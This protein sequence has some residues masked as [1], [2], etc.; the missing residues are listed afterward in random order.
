M[1]RKHSIGGKMSTSLWRICLLAV[2]SIATVVSI[3]SSS[4]AQN[5]RSSFSL[6][7]SA[8]NSRVKMG[9]PIWLDV[10]MENTSDHEISVYRENTDDQGGFVYKADVRDQTGATAPETK[11]GRRIQGHDTPEERAHE[12]YVMLTSGGESKLGAGKK[13]VERINLTNLYALNRPGKYT[14]QLQRMDM[15]NQ[16]TVLSNKITIAVTP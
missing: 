6:A 16:N 3:A 4:V 8:V 2:I 13:I 9:A 11:F 5:A 1:T 7:I 14:I 12:P 15:E 10:T